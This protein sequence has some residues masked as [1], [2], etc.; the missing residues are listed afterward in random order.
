M[1]KK[2]SNPLAR[3]RGFI[4]AGATLLTNLHLPNF[5]KGTLYQGSGKYVC[6]PGLNCYSCPGAAGA[7]PVGAFQAVIGSSKFRFSY[8]ITGILILFGVLLGRFICGFLCPFGWFQ[9]LLHK[10]PSP[11]LSTKKL[12]PLRYLKYAVLLVMVVLLPLL[13]VN[14]LGMGDP[15]FCKYLCPQGV[16]EGAIPLSLT[17]A[18]IRAALGKLFTWKACILLAVIVGS[19]VFY[20]PF[21]KWLCPLGAFYALLNKVSLFQMRVDTHKCVSCGACA[22]AC[23]MDVDITKTPNHAECIRCGMCMKACPT[24]AIQYK[25]GWETNQTLKRQ[26]SKTMKLN[27]VTALL[28]GLVLAFSLAACGQGASS[29]STASSSAS[30]AAA[31][32]KTEEQLLAEENEILSANDA[33]WE[34]VFSSMD[35]N[36]T[37]TTLS[38]NYGDF[39]LSAVEKAKDQFSDEEYKTLTADAEK[40]R[41]IENQ[42]AALAPAEDAASGAAAQGTAFPQFEGNDLEGNPVDNSLFA[43]NA[44]TVVNFWFNGCKPCVEELDDLNALNEKVKAQG[45]EVVGINT[46]TLDGNQQGIDAAKKLLATKG[47]S[48]RN[49]YFASGSEAGKFALNIMAFPTTYVFDRDGNVVGQPLLGGIDKEEN[50]AALQKKY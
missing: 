18:G 27:R 28:L 5:A 11:K 42:I 23:K 35:K 31:E 12:K 43:G 9:E 3:F 34:K 40:I 21:C 10:I 2:K 45:G 46:E 6:V 29:D 7:C 36:V 50:L 25:F 33:L 47:A 26:R 15:F 24:D 38:T 8:Y 13:A 32:G 16:L 22:K 30:S 37:E 41:D 44:F 49:I 39:L 1:D 14:E 20:R 4:Q 17:N 19:V 48:Y